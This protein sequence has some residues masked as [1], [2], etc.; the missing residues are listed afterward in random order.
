MAD[1]WWLAVG[2]IA[3]MI[4]AVLAALQEVE[5]SGTLKG[6]V[7]WKHRMTVLGAGVVAIGATGSVLVN[8]SNPIVWALFVAL[9][10][11]A[12][13]VLTFLVVAAALWLR[14]RDKLKRYTAL[15]VSATALSFIV[16]WSPVVA[17]PLSDLAPERHDAK[18]SDAERVE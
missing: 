7:A 1:L 5:E 16:L 2:A 18:R 14:N 12:A 13:L 15:R 17:K 4:G 8:P 10:L 3:L 9:L 11:V 6:A